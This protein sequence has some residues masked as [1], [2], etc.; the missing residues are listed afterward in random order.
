LAEYR[1]LVPVVEGSNP[2]TPGLNLK[3]KNNEK[4]KRRNH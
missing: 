2:S 4:E 1:I 3:E